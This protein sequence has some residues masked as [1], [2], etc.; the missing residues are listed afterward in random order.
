MKNRLKHLLEKHHILIT[1]ALF[2]LLTVA[3]NYGVFWGMNA[4]LSRVSNRFIAEHVYLLAH[5]LSW[6]ISVLFSY[7]VTKHFVFRIRCDGI[8]LARFFSFI[9]IRAVTELGALLA[10]YLLVTVLSLNTYVM[11]FITDVIQVLVNYFFTKGVSFNGIDEKLKGKRNKA[12]G[13]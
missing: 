13:N 9:L 6:I 5:V 8:H 11:K 2:G 4:P 7:Y 12:E 10:M 1:Y 3:V